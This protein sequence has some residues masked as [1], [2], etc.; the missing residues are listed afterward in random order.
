MVA[1]LEEGISE[2]QMLLQVSRALYICASAVAAGLACDP[3]CTVR[4]FHPWQIAADSRD[5]QQTADPSVTSLSVAVVCDTGCFLAR[6]G[7]SVRGGQCEVQQAFDKT[8][9]GPQR[10]VGDL[11]S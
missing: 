1:S 2:A 8:G 10:G 3:H 9:G 5:P 4:E 6:G 7:H 11:C